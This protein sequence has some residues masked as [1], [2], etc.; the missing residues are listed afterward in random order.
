MFW[1]KIELRQTPLAHPQSCPEQLAFH[2]SNGQPEGV[3]FTDTKDECE[4]IINNAELLD[5]I[6]TLPS[7][8]SP[9]KKTMG[10]FHPKP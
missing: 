10:R 2:P 7:R 9:Q 8:K 6:Y 4:A 1:L 5:S 3:V